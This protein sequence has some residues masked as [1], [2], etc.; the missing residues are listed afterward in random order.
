MDSPSVKDGESRLRGI[1]RVTAG[2]DESGGETTRSLVPL[3]VLAVRRG[4]ILIVLLSLH[5]GLWTGTSIGHG[6]GVGVVRHPSDI[7]WV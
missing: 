2:R 1:D 4:A 5:L 3:A 7:V 6:V